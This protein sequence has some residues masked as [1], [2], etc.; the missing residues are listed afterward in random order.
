MPG[1][2]WYISH[3]L[4]DDPIQYLPQGLSYFPT[5]II[6]TVEDNQYSSRLPAISMTYH[7]LSPVL[8]IFIFN[9][10]MFLVIQIKFHVHYFQSLWAPPPVPLRCAPLFSVWYTVCVSFGLSHVMWSKLRSSV[11]SSGLFLCVHPPQLGLTWF[12]WQKKSIY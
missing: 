8:L 10:T 6:P 7:V 5:Q 2:L 12:S 9:L 1:Y 11:P 3:S 4:Y